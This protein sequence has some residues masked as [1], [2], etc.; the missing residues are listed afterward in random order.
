MTIRN[1]NTIEFN[2]RKACINSYSDHSA[3]VENMNSQREL[4]AAKFPDAIVKTE[5]MS[6]SDTIAL[7]AAEKDKA[8]EIGNSSVATS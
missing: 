5:R 1:V 6:H 8:W 2:G 4:W 7:V 3:L